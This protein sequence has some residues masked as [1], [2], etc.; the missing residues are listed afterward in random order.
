MC[1]NIAHRAM[2]AAQIAEVGHRKFDA[3]E[4]IF[5]KLDASINRFPW[6]ICRT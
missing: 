5:A 6:I 1:E 2:L 4:H 3:G